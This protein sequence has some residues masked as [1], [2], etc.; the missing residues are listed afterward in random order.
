MFYTTELLA[1]ELRKLA[2]WGADPER[3]ARMPVLRELARIE[4][5]LRSYTAGSIMG[6][7]L[8]EC[9]EALPEGLYEFDG[10]RYTAS[11][12]KTGFYLELR[13]GTTASHPDRQFRLMQLLGLPYS[14]RQW[15]RHPRLERGFLVI[16]AEHMVKR[17]N[18]QTTGQTS[19]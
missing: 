5:G 17:V 19:V 10:R 3:L 11:I 14:Y 1:D 2:G 15:G 9:I 18:V 13:I 12:M 6:R 7:Y 4:P 16:L 8:V